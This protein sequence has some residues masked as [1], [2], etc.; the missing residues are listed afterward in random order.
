MLCLKTIKALFQLSH[1]IDV[2]VHQWALVIFINL[3]HDELGVTSDDELS[4]PKVC[5]DPETGK[6]SF[7]LCHVVRRSL[8]GKM[9]LDDVLEVLSGGCNE[10]H[11]GTGA[12]QR[13]GSIKVH[14]PCLI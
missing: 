10:Q 11:A 9:H 6:Q 12:L 2:C 14:D 4:D 3:P 5:R 7:I 1:F 8:P 13:K